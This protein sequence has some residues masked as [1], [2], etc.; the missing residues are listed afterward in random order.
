[1][2]YCK[3]GRGTEKDTAEA[4]RLVL[5][6][7]YMLADP[8]RDQTFVDGTKTYPPEANNLRTWAQL[9][10]LLQRPWFER[11]WVIQEISV[12]QRAMVLCGRYMLLWSQLEAAAGYILR[13]SGIPPKYHVQKILPLMGAHRATQ[14]SLNSIWNIDE[15]SILTILHSTQETKCLDLRDKLFAI[16]GIVKDK[17]DIEIDYSIPVEQV[18]RNWAEKRIRRTQT[19]DILSACADST[20][21]GDLPSWV[22][23]LRRSFGQDKPLWIFSHI[24]GYKHILKDVWKSEADRTCQDLYFSPDGSAL[25][26]KGHQVGSIA[27]L[28][29][30][31]DVVNNLQNPTDLNDRLQEIL[32]D[33]ERTANNAVSSSSAWTFRKDLFQKAILRDSE[34]WCSSIED[35]HQAYDKWACVADRIGERGPEQRLRRMANR[36]LER[37]LFP[38]VHGCQIFATSDE[39]HENAGAVAANCRAQVGDELWILTGGLTPFVL[40]RVSATTHRPISPCYLYANMGCIAGEK[41]KTAVLRRVMLV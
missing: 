3:P 13:P 10:R 38:R 22:P 24:T 2:G 30:I 9:S 33:W 26:V 8:A 29:T 21:S 7:T 31:G 23:D 6:L 37:F 36:E 35:I 39:I 12:S 17:E 34:P 28:S 40:R 11:L 25:T 41:Q 18:Y 32:V 5:C 14:V 19:L 4:T 27:H 16:L 15:K 1:M 20:R